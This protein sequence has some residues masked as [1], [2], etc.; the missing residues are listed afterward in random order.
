MVKSEQNERRHCFKGKRVVVLGG[1]SGI[2]FAAA[3]AAAREGASLVVVSS[4]KERVDRAVSRLPEGTQGY[5]VDIT[6]E[7]QVRQFFSEI[8]EFDHLVFTAGD[9]L[10]VE[11][12]DATDVDTAQRWFNV[13]YWGAFMAA[14]YG[15]RNIRR[16]G[17][18]TLTSGVAGV[19]PQKGFTVSASICGA[20]ESLTRALAVELSSLRVN[21]VCFG[22]MRTELWDDIPEEQRNAMYEH[23]GKSLPVGRVGEPEDGAEAFLY[24]MR[25]KYSTGQ[26]IV[27]DGG[28]TLV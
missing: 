11:S 16:G 18:I 5:A 1:T 15:S 8:G 24:L 23:T 4:Q 22:L 9:P 7:E 28:S 17:S 14:K 26:I 20:V 21:A 27:V 2:G 19:R 25:E 10:M 13:R 3:E 6:N 12:L